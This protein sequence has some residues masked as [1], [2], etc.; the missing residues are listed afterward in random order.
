MRSQVMRM[1]VSC[2]VREVQKALIRVISVQNQLHVDHEQRASGRGAYV[3]PATECID[4]ALKRRMFAKAL[5]VSTDVDVTAL[6][7]LE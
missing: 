2:R 7:G 5:R 4:N 3:H 1:C 6:V